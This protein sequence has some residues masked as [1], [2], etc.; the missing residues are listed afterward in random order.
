MYTH[1]EVRQV[2]E[3]TGIMALDEPTPYTP[4]EK[5]GFLFPADALQVLIGFWMTQKI[6][7]KIVGPEGCGK[8]ELIK[9]FHAALRY[10]LLQPLCGPRTDEADLRGQVLPSEEGGFR[11]VYGHVVTAMQYGCSVFLDEYNLLP[12]SV[13]TALNP[14]LDGA[15]VDIPET[16][17]VIVPQPSFRVFVA[18]NP[19]DKALGFHG[20]NEE[21]ISNKARFVTYKM[22]YG[23][24]QE[25][26]L[27]KDVLVGS[28]CFDESFAIGMAAQMVSLAKKIRR[29]YMADSDEAN[30]LEA[31]MST[32]SLLA[33]ATL[34]GTPVFGSMKAPIRTTLQLAYLNA[35]SDE[36][37]EAVSQFVTEI[38]GNEQ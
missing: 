23:D 33:W 16:G 3:K 11:Y 4:A 12:S 31:T 35:H 25:E 7:L 14:I 34:M 15:K 1:E 36:F 29:L 38:F 20:R 22:G 26:K 19:N 18:Q 17:E 28:G 2:C 24:E 37:N 27:V 21:D 32:R 8:S 13:I 5:A 9:Q 10:P 30:A 6:G